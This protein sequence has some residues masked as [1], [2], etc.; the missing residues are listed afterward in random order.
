MIS[1][2]EQKSFADF[3]LQIHDLCLKFQF[4]QRSNSLFIVCGV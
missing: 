4:S 3:Y 2:H 1:W